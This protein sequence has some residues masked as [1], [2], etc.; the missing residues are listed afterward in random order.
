MVKQKLIDAHSAYEAVTD[1]SGQASTKS[2]Y[3][4][5]WKAGK[6]VLNL[7]AVDAVEVVRCKNCT[8]AVRDE[9]SGCYF[10]HGNHVPAEHY[11]SYGERRKEDGKGNL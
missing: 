10:C 8:V 2:A 4:A 7:P 1:L 6:T 9:Y 11:C 5:F 3:A